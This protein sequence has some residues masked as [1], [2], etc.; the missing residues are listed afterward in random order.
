MDSTPLEQ[1]R[2]ALEEHFGP[3]RYFGV[4][5]ETGSTQDLARD[6]IASAPATAPGAVFVAHH[7]TAGRGR[8]GRPWITPPGSALT[9][10]L[11][12]RATPA[13]AERLVLATSV[14]VAEALD[15]WLEPVGRAAAIKWPNDL[16]VDGRKIAGILVETRDHAAAVGVGINV[17]LTAEQLPPPLRAQTTSL[18]QCGADVDRLELLLE[19]LTQVEHAWNQRHDDRL[20]QAWEER[21]RMLGHDVRLSHDGR[22]IDGQVIGLHPRDGLRVRR[23]T[24]EVVH[25]PAATTTVIESPR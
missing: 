15:R 20:L 6:L 17:G 12:F 23:H 22:I 19:T 1:W 25:L 8:L 18:G 16:Y 13:E 2:D 21:C 14:G 10:S 4:Y 5:R 9:F 7:Q 24:G 3:N 11:A